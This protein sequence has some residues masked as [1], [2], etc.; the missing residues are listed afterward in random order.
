MFRSKVAIA[1]VVLSLGVLSLGITQGKALA[2]DT[3]A[4]RPINPST[5]LAPV[6][7][8]FTRGAKTVFAVVAKNGVLNR[9]FGASRAR[10]VLNGRY[11]V[12]FNR[13]VRRCAYTATLGTTGFG[14]EP[15][16][17]VTVATRAG[18]TN[19]VW[20]ATNNSS[21]NAVDRNFHLAVHCP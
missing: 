21:G 5:R 1:S 10:K 18:T 19:G 3:N 14:T 8:T 20:V 12:F 13:D 16:G 7:T 9:G 6:T 15:S 4:P 17:E 2:Q 11:E